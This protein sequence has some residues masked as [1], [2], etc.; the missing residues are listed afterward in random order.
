MS[1]AMPTRRNVVR[2][3]AWTVPVVAAGV[4]APAYA[5]SCHDTTYDWRLDWGAAS[6]SWAQPAVVSG[7]QTGDAVI[8]GAAG[9]TAMRVT[10]RSEMFG[11]MQRDV[12]NLKLSN[13]IG[14]QSTSNVGGLNQGP[15][16]NISHAAAIPSG[17][18]NRQEVQI[19]F[20]RAVT[21]L[22]FTI[23]DTDWSNGGWDDR[24][25]L[26][27][28]R[29][30]SSTGIQGA[31]VLNDPW[32]AINEGNA[33]NSSGTRN[34]TVT[35]SSLAANTAITLTFWNDSGNSNQR[36][37]LSDFTFRAIGC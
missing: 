6:T 15:G 27:G 2:T 23:S 32:M 20:N 34:I 14:N 37:F 21:N 31:G 18:N 1:N 9:S 28:S 5:A 33:G 29:A 30:V 10:F 12:N 13:A 11:T 25:E 26:T 7:I 36:V 17:R 22:S 8:S 3:A 35:Y 24:V 19:T 16:L 4:A